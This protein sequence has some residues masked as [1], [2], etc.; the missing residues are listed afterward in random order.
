M[1]NLKELKDIKGKR[2]LVRIDFNLPIS[3]GVVEDDFRIQK[4]LPTVQYLMKKGAKVILISHLGKDGESLEPVAKVLNKYI[5]AK[6]IDSV[7]GENVTKAVNEMKNGEVILLENLRRDKGEQ[8]ANQIFALELA[9]LGDVYVN[10]AFPVSHREDASIV[11]LPKILP[12]YAGFQLEAEVEHLSQVFNKPKK[13]FLFI[14]GGAKLSTKEPLVEKYL[15][16][17]DSVFI[18]GALLNNVL[19]TLGYEVGK[20]LVDDAV[21][22]PK[23]ALENKKLILPTDVLVESG[24]DLINKK[25]S[26]IKKHEMI[27]DVGEESIR[28]LEPLI[29][30]AKLILWNGPLGRYEGGGDK[31]TKALLKM[32]ASSKATSIIG[33]GDTVAVISQMKLE[34]KFTFVSTGGGATLDFLAKGTLPGIEAL[35]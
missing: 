1:R 10:E 35:S 28:N 33:G 13:P 9:K 18:G 31:A 6:F 25:I 17:A 26:E 15:K 27:I 11:L 8:S 34:K 3:N 7:L 30:K 14:L 32:I 22:M 24:K 19:E 2:V 4:E 29:K 21:S 23:T 20:S 12:S 5:K 16:L